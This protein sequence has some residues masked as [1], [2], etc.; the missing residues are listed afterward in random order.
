MELTGLFI[1]VLPAQTAADNHG[2]DIIYVEVKRARE[3]GPFEGNME[4]RFRKH[5][6]DLVTAERRPSPLMVNLTHSEAKYLSVKFNASRN[7]V[8]PQD[9]SQ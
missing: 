3:S 8:R 5:D 2:L 9:G 1:Q 6:L 4:V 7:I